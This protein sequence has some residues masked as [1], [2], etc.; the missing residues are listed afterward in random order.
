MRPYMSIKSYTSM[1]YTQ[2]TRKTK[3]LETQFELIRQR[4]VLQWNPKEGNTMTDEEMRIEFKRLVEEL[5][6]EDY[7]KVLALARKLKAERDQKDQKN[8]KAP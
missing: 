2:F 8:H 6:H 3:E 1:C 4:N 7:E 5:S